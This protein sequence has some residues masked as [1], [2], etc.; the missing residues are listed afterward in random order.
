[1]KEI[2]FVALCLILMTMISLREVSG[3]EPGASTEVPDSGK[4]IPWVI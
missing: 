1:M 3:E 2:A 4:R